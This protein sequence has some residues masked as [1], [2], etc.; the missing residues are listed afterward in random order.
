[1]TLLRSR[2]IGDYLDTLASPSPA[3]GG[4]SVT[5]LVGALAAALGQMVARIT[6]QSA[7]NPTLSTAAT[8]LA[9]STDALLAAAE[10]DETCFPGYLAA[11]R[12]PKATDAEKAIRRQAMQEAIIYAAE[13]PLSLA[14]TAADVLELLEPVAREG[15]AHAASDTAIGINL[16]EAAVM[17]ALSNVRANIPLIKREESANHFTNAAAALETSTTAQATR[18]REILSNR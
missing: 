12:L 13:V 14:S 9:H 18:L 1:M 15:T 5:G 4:G 2:T 16:A 6:I 3:P 7:P 11:S 8:R 10:Q 17:A